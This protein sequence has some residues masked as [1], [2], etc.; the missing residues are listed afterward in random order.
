MSVREQLEEELRRRLVNLLDGWAI[1][2]TGWRRTASAR[3]APAWHATRHTAL[4]STIEFPKDIK[5]VKVF[6]GNN[7]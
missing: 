1:V 7:G 5:S 4:A 3:E 2:A 6:S